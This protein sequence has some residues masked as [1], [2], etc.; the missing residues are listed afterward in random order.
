MSG[1]HYISVYSHN[2]DYLADYD[3]S[4]VENTTPA[5]TH[6][7]IADYLTD[8]FWE[9]RTFNVEPGGALTV[10]I[11]DLNEAGQQLAR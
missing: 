6:D 1:I 9:R 7:E 8:G 4:I 3:I 2:S 5:G 10:Y 11:T